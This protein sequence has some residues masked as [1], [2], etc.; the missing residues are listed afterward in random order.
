MVKN[1]KK[2]FERVKFLFLLSTKKKPPSLV[3]GLI[4]E[5]AE[6]LEPTTC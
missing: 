6:G 3:G 4:T 5:P 2:E 1:T